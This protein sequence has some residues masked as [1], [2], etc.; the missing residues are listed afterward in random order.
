[1]VVL[2]TSQKIY[3]FNIGNSRA[4]LGKYYSKKNKIEPFQIT[5]DHTIARFDERARILKSGGTISPFKNE[6]GEELG[7]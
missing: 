3:T 7:P 4:V 1:M 2:I 6:K 5:H